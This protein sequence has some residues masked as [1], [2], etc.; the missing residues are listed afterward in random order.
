MTHSFTVQPMV[1]RLQGRNIMAKGM[2]ENAAV[3]MVTGRA[4]KESKWKETGIR[5]ST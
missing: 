1:G 3:L 2:V 4:E 5:Y